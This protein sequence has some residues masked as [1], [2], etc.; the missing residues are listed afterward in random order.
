MA[1]QTPLTN[2]AWIRK[3]RSTGYFYYN[4]V[5]F[6]TSNYNQH[7][8]AGLCGGVV[9][10]LYWVQSPCLTLEIVVLQEIQCILYIPQNWM[11]YGNTLN[12][13]FPCI[14]Q[15]SQTWHPRHGTQEHDGFT[16]IKKIPWASSRS[17]TSFQVCS[18]SDLVHQI[19]SFLIFRFSTTRLSMIGYVNIV[20][21]DFHFLPEG[22]ATIN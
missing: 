18:S 9:Q 1:A 2:R 19:Y 13:I 11:L 6:L 5:S 17:E 3:A 8:T 7:L 20:R 14:L 12:P 22:E 16:E 21:V 15:I 10:R 4:L